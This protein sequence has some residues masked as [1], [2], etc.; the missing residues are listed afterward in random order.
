MMLSHLS[1]TRLLFTLSIAF[2]LHACGGSGPALTML[3]GRKQHADSAKPLPK[4]SSYVQELPC[5]PLAEAFNAGLAPGRLLGGMEHADNGDEKS[6]TQQQD[7]KRTA[8][9]RYGLVPQ[10]IDQD[11]NCL[12]RAVADQLQKEPFNIQFSTSEDYHRTIR[13][14]AVEHVRSNR[15]AYESSFPYKSLD[16]WLNKMSRDKEWG[17]QVAIRALADALQVTIVAVRAEATGGE[18]PTIYKSVQSSGVIYLHYRGGSHYESLSPLSPKSE[19][20]RSNWEA[21]QKRIEGYESSDYKPSGSVN[22]QALTTATSE[23]MEKKKKQGEDISMQVQQWCLD[24][25]D[26]YK[27]TQALVEALNQ[28][29]DLQARRGL[30]H[31][32]QQYVNNFAERELKALVVSA[33]REAYLAAYA[34]LAETAPKDKPTKELLL[35]YFTS[36][37]NQ[38]PDQRIANEAYLMQLL[39]DVL[40]AI[41]PTTFNK[42]TADVEEL[43]DKLFGR[44]KNLNSQTLHAGNYSI[45]SSTFEALYRAY[46]LLSDI[47]GKERRWKREDKV[48]KRTKEDLQALKKS[49][50]KGSYYLFLHQLYRIEGSLK[51]LKERDADV[52]YSTAWKRRGK[53]FGQGLGGLVRMLTSIRAS[54]VPG[55]NQDQFLRGAKSLI[56]AFHRQGLFRNKESLLKQ[57]KDLS[58]AMEAIYEGKP[59]ALEAFAKQF[60]AFRKE[61]LKLVSKDEEKIRII[62][63]YDLVEKLLSL[64]HQSQQGSVFARCKELAE[65]LSKQFKEQQAGYQDPVRTRQAQQIQQALG[66]GFQDLKSVREAAPAEDSF[67]K[68]VREQMQQ[69]HALRESQAALQKATEELFKQCATKE[70]LTKHHSAFEKSIQRWIIKSVTAKLGGRLA[71]TQRT[72]ISEMGRETEKVLTHLQKHLE[73]VAKIQLLTTSAIQKGFE[74]VSDTFKQVAKRQVDELAPKLATLESQGRL[75]AENFQRLIPGIKRI[76]DIV[77]NNQRGIQEIG[78]RSEELLKEVSGLAKSQEELKDVV[79]KFLGTLSSQGEVSSRNQQV[80]LGRLRRIDLGQQIAQK[81]RASQSELMILQQDVRRQIAMDLVQG[82]YGSLTTRVCSGSLEQQFSRYCGAILH[83]IQVSQEQCRDELEDVDDLSY[84]SLGLYKEA[85]EAYKRAAKNCKQQLARLY[86]LSG[87]L[88]EFLPN[89]FGE[90]LSGMRKTAADIREAVKSLPPEHFKYLTSVLSEMDETEEKIEKALKQMRAEP[91]GVNSQATLAITDG[92]ERDKD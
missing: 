81:E 61:L 20:Q 36:I 28:A 8:A 33:D 58:E 46:D 48:Y 60:E 57:H 31:W 51:H 43:S 72:L 63:S 59:E 74:M 40:P 86:E 10:E 66:E 32:L 23:A 5:D 4:E 9:T 62:L 2:M 35:S 88:P 22:I 19:I 38:V 16:D 26:R 87:V 73:G 7:V 3:S 12:F 78:Q 75:T 21:L 65:G 42:S 30:C 69:K 41:D 84:V 11:G 49:V 1:Y 91:I 52:S 53:R 39:A 37:Y 34:T 47:L 70:D 29:T 55:V 50:K 90:I 44:I 82:Q 6:P 14:I 77:Q 79:L 80:I 71:C 45:Y 56:A 76:E 15:A 13:R 54:V 83:T 25:R 18:Q 85:R 89:N 68:E 64:A 27:T 17:G 67:F 24:N 92:K